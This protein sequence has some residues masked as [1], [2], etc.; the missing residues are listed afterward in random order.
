MRRAEAKGAESLR[1]A[2]RGLLATVENESELQRR[3]RQL[4]DQ[5]ADV[6]AD[7][8]EVEV[9][10][11]RRRGAEA[12]PP[13]GRL[14]VDRRVEAELARDPAALLGATRDPDDAA[15]LD[16]GDLAHDRSRGPCRRGHDHGLARPGL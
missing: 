5:L 9:H 12:V 16:P 4:P 3:A 2:L 13:V 8:L 14:V 15:A 11:A 6:A 1:V 10:A 7:V